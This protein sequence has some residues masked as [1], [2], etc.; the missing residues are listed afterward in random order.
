MTEDAKEFGEKAIVYCKS[1]LR[2]HDTGWCTVGIRDKVKLD[3]T[4]IKDAV[5]ECRVKG[6]VLFSDLEKKRA[7]EKIEKEAKS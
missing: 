5:D 3:S 4:T 2:P 1:H 6:Y 7:E